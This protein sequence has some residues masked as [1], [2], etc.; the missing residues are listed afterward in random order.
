[1]MILLS[2][3]LLILLFSLLVISLF[4]CRRRYYGPQYYSEGKSVLVQVAGRE[5]DS[6]QRL[7]HY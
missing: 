5:S 3:L 2:L 7:H 1:M 6:L 4:P